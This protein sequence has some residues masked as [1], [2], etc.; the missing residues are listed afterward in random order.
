MN[1]DVLR[2]RYL[3]LIFRRVFVPK[4]RKSVLV[5]GVESRLK[6]IIFDLVTEHGWRLIALEIMP[7][8]VHLFINS[9]PHESASQSFLQQLRLI[10]MEFIRQTSFKWIFTR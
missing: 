6:N 5:G 10:N 8:R 9:P 7:D 4:R 1:T 2:N 3:Q